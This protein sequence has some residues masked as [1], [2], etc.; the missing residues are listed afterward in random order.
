MPE[1]QDHYKSLGVSK[2]SSPREVRKAYYNLSKQ[3]H[4]DVGG[5]EEKFKEI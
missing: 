4:P 2:N 5:S 1:D 3:H